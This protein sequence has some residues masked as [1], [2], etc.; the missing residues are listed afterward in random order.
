MK[1]TKIYLRKFRGFLNEYFDVLAIKV[2]QFLHSKSRLRGLFFDSLPKSSLV[3]STTKDGI[4]YLGNTSDKEIAR[5]VYTKR[6]SFDASYVEQSLR[7]I[8][9]KKSTLIEVGANIGTVGINAVYN[10]HVQNCISFE[11]DPLN[12]KLRQCNVSLNNLEDRFELHN[13]ALTSADHDTVEF[14]L[15]TENFGDHRIKYVDTLGRM[16]EEK[17]KVIKV[18][19]DNLNNVCSQLDLDDCLLLMDA[20]G[21]EGHILSSARN[22]IDRRVPI[23]IEFWPYGLHRNEGLELLYTALGGAPYE[24]IYDLKHPSEPIPFCDKNL[25]KIE[26]QLG[27]K[28][29]FTDLLLF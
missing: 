7:I 15:D 16:G 20:Q 12:F 14:E 6:E 9:S 24:M 17:R 13:A 1:S 23:I 10:E 27:R 18:K 29:R 28:G 3:I 11:P 2:F 19:A 22:L 25:K 4:H 21:S 8:G 5:K 26:T